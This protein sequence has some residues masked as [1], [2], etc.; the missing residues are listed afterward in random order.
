[1][2][3]KVKRALCNEHGIT[4]LETAII[5]IAFVV[6]AAIFA[7]T[8]LSTGTFLTE[9]SKE[10]AYAGLEEARGSLELKGSVVAEDWQDTEGCIDRLYFDLGLAASGSSVD[11][12]TT[13]PKV[14]FIYRDATHNVNIPAGDSH[15]CCGS[16]GW[17]TTITGCPGGCSTMLV[18]GALAKITI[19][20]GQIYP[21]PTTKLLCG[22]QAFSIE[23]IPPTGGTLLIERTTPPEITE[24]TDLH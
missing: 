20:F 24:I 12:Q 8:I 23:I 2:S 15:M 7:F 5:L 14:R 21:M 17:W 6:V 19:D 11:L 1:M 9:R 16:G 22:N 18:P 4:A 10:A 3:I 13:N